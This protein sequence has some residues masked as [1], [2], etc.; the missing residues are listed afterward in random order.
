[1]NAELTA[2]ADLREHKIATWKALAAAT[3]DVAAAKAR[4]S[5]VA[6]E[7]GDERDAADAVLFEATALETKAWNAASA[8]WRRLEEAR[9]SGPRTTGRGMPWQMR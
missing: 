6:G 1:V 9:E 5:L 7:P 4:L 3:R 2:L 8:A